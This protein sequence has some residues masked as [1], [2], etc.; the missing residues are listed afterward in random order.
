M[1]KHL[2]LLQQFCLTLGAASFELISQ[3][4]QLLCHIVL[5]K[6]LHVSRLIIIIDFFQ[7]LYLLEKVLLLFE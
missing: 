2:H 7:K 3:E 5:T 1:S 4:L 6:G